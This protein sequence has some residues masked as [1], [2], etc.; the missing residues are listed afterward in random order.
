M[1]SNYLYLCWGVSRYVRLR[2]TAHLVRA[3]V[4]DV[5][6][7]LACAVRTSARIPRSVGK[8]NRRNHVVGGRAKVRASHGSKI[9]WVRDRIAGQIYVC[10]RL[11]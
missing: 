10:N 9:R 8:P 6:L 4:N 11:A 7:C 3:S 5:Q 1:T 2:S